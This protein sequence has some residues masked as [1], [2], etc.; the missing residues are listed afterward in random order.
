MGVNILSS[1]FKMVEDVF[2][3]TAKGYS[4]RRGFFWHEAIAECTGHAKQCEGCGDGRVKDASPKG[5]DV[6]LAEEDDGVGLYISR[7]IM[8]I[9]TRLLVQNCRHIFLIVAGGEEHSPGLKLTGLGIIL[10]HDLVE[11]SGAY[12]ICVVHYYTV[13]QHRLIGYP[14]VQRETGRFYAIKTKNVCKMPK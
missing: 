7:M 3:E 10:R 14:F 1:F 8:V 9:H 11:P 6:G 12:L 13:W 2:L 4:G 5:D